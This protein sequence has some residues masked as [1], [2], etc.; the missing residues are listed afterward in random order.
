MT[1]E[2]QLVL[3]GD[4]AEFLLNNEAFKTT[5]ESLVELSFQAFCMS[6][7]ENTNGRERTYA[8]YRALCELVDTL[9]QRVSVRDEINERA[10]DNRSEEE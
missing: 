10:S 7:P 8:H 4:D 1:Q 5:I 3:Q 2:E 6:E 9:K